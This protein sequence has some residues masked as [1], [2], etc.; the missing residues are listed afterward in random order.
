VKDLIKDKEETEVQQQLDME[1]K[2]KLAVR[3]LI[4]SCTFLLLFLL[5][6]LRYYAEIALENNPSGVFTKYPETWWAI[7]MLTLLFPMVAGVCFSLAL[8]VWQNNRSYCKS[9]KGMKNAKKSLEEAIKKHLMSQKQY[10]NAKATLKDWIDTN[11]FLPNTRNY[12]L[13]AYKNGYWVDYVNPETS[14]TIQD[15]VERMTDF[16]NK[17]AARRNLSQL[18][19]T[20]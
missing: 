2:I 4:L 5:S 20:K 15:I 19:N 7:F 17:T 10:E 12:L 3:I 1:V 18:Y 13:A 11:Q 8:K 6:R 16:R 14:D 9:K